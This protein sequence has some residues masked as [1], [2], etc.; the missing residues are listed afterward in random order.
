MK[1]KCVVVLTARGKSRILEEGGSQAWRLNAHHAG[2]CNYV[3][4]VQNRKKSWGNPEA[5]HHTAFLVG[6]ISSISRSQEKAW[7]SWAIPLFIHW[8]VIPKKSKA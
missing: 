8:Q 4:C 1:D 3:V 7:L 6:K 5:S 2:K